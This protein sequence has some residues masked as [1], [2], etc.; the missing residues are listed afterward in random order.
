M[1]N[2]E[3]KL[4]YKYEDRRLKLTL[5]T[6]RVQLPLACSSISMVDGIGGDGKN[7]LNMMSKST[8][9]V[10]MSSHC[11]SFVKPALINFSGQLGA[12]Q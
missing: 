10:Q 1:L 2:V 12:E 8:D 7:T 3:W 5:A 11:Y 6:Q 9:V 4:M